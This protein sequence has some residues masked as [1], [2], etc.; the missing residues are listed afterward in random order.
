M[1]DIEND[2][3]HILSL[4]DLGLE[5]QLDIDIYSSFKAIYGRILKLQRLTRKYTFLQSL[6]LFSPFQY[7]PRSVPE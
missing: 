3:K 2:K 4:I 1:N 7:F 6:F 5:N